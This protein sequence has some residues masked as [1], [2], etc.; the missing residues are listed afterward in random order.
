MFEQLTVL[1]TVNTCLTVVEHLTV[2]W[3]VN[4]WCSNMDKYD[5]H[6]VMEPTE[7]GIAIKS[8]HK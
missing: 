8:K 4:S 7:T 3:T 6:W 5:M 1:W 2:L